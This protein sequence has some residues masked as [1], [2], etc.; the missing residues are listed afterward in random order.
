MRHTIFGHSNYTQIQL[1]I[2]Q[3]KL[4]QA[5]TVTKTLNNQTPNKVVPT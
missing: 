1:T 3:L 2:T 5:V 4:N